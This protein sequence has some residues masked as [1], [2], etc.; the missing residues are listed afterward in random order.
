LK[1]LVILTGYSGAG[2]STAAGLLED[3]GF[4]C[5]DNLPP[6]VTYQV[7]SLVL[8]SVDKLAIVIDIRGYMFGNVK[9]AIADVKERFPFTKVV[10]LTATK[11]TLVPAICTYKKVSPT[12]KTNH[13]C[14]GSYRP[15]NRNDERRS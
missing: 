12:F 7:A 10:F 3:L 4:F 8:P 5:I 2:K 11:E 15:G 1:E 6:E 13:I 9:K 14:N